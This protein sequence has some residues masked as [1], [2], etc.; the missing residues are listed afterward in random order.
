M[1]DAL[2]VVVKHISQDADV[3]ALCDIRIAP[4]HKYSNTTVAGAWKTPAKGIELQYDPGGTPDIEQPVQNIRIRASCYGEDDYQ[5]SRVYNTLVHVC[6]NANRIVVT[7]SNG[8]AFLYW[9][10]LDSSPETQFNNDI[11]MPFVQVFL[12]ARI[13]EVPI[14]AS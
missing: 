9:L 2:A 3:M 14:T 10:L 5:A 6:R 7:T 1:I 8:I 12:T 4:R 11:S 13:A